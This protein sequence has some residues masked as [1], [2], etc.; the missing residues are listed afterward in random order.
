MKNSLAPESPALFGLSVLS[1]PASNR[2]V[3][4]GTPVKKEATVT[5]VITGIT[6][7][8][9]SLTLFVVMTF[10]CKFVIVKFHLSAFEITY[11]FCAPLVP[12]SFIG[13]K[14][15]AP[16]SV[17]VLE[18]PKNMF[19][20]LVGRCITG[21]LT[22]VILFLA[23]TYTSYSKAFAINKTESLF[24]PFIAYFALGEAVRAVDIL[25]IILSFG[26]MLLML[27]PWSS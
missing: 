17:D 1:S 19:W 22:D 25:G 9:F 4:E 8:L 6:L 2:K 7:L 21:F 14:F 11:S 23:F 15:I 18:I 27:Q 16:K 12:I 5:E 13:V 3:I 26:G 20:P 10:L 24:S